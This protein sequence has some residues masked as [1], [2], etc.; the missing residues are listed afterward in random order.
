MEKVSHA[1]EGE[2][3]RT[4]TVRDENLVADSNMAQGKGNQDFFVFLKTRGTEKLELKIRWEWR[5][6]RER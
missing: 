4:H 1:F 5:V 6:R 3:P 2:V